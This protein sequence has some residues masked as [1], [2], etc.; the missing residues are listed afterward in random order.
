MC[1]QALMRFG[2]TIAFTI[3]PIMRWAI[4]FVMD[5]RGLCELGGNQRCAIMCAEV[6]WWRCHRRVVADYLLAAGEQVFHLIGPGNIQ[7]AH[8]TEAAR[9]PASGALTYPATH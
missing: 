5:S 9:S 3:S 7:L 6:L 2:T 1:R 4:V 8:M